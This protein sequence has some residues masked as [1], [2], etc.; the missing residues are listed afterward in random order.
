MKKYLIALVLGFFMVA[1]GKGDK[2]DPGSNGQDGAPGAVGSTGPQGD[3]GENGTEVTVKQFC[4]GTTHYPDT[5]CEVGF[6]VNGKLYA[7][8]S[9]HGGFSTEIAPGDYRSNGLNC[10]CD[11]TVTS[12]CGIQ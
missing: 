8:Y 11:F 5:F 9:T 2:G 12:N 6:C 4:P 10:S 3:P 7:T 1:C